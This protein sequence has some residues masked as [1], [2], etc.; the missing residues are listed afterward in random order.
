[1]AFLDSE[2]PSPVRDARFA[3][4][5][6]T[7]PAIINAARKRRRLHQVNA[8][9][10]PRD[11]RLWAPMHDLGK[12]TR[13]VPKLGHRHACIMHNMRLLPRSSA[14]NDTHTYCT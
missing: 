11:Y 2:M 14:V 4:K 7:E 12:E 6:E 13:R 3:P 8:V 10:R 1:M 5:Q 9:L